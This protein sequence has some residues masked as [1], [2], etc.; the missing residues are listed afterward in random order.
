MLKC[1]PKIKYATIES[2]FSS[3]TGYL[4]LEELSV[5]FDEKKFGTDPIFILL[6]KICKNSMKLKTETLLMFSDE[7]N[8]ENNMRS[9]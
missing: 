5:A 7:Y 2:V 6:V 8:E 9:L 3:P 4:N 1:Y